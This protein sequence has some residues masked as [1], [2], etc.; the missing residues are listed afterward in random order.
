MKASGI[1][2]LITLAVVVCFAYAAPGWCCSK[3]GVGPGGH[4]AGT[5]GTPAPTG[6]EDHHVPQGMDDN[7]VNIHRE[8]ADD[9]SRPLGGSG[10]PGNGDGNGSGVRFTDDGSIRGSHLSPSPGTEDGEQGDQGSSAGANFL[11][12][13]LVGEAMGVYTKEQ[14]DRLLD[15]IFSSP[16]NQPAAP[17]KKTTRLH[18]SEGYVP[19]SGHKND[20]K[21]EVIHIIASDILPPT[22]YLRDGTA[23][24]HSSYWLIRV[25]GWMGRTGTRAT[26]R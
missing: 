6:G 17:P 22:N 24:Y 25:F 18:Y 15:L 10:L 12:D 9:A 4:P 21:D 13:L 19:V 11:A 1:L 5:S 20:A 7:A 3:H 16:G 2:L 23:E 8:G 14:V 26:E